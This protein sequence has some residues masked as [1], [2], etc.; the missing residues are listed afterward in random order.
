V[1]TLYLR[2][3]DTKRGTGTDEIL[4]RNVHAILYALFS[5]SKRSST[6]PTMGNLD[7]AAA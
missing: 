5:L 3:F 7:S 1:R 4:G 6:L 2:V